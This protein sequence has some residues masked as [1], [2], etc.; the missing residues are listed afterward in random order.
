MKD[1]KNNKVIKGIFIVL[2]FLILFNFVVPNYSNAV[3]GWTGKLIEPLADLTC[4]LGDSMLN[5]MQGVMM[6]GSPTAIVQRTGLVSL[7]I[8]TNSDNFFTKFLAET[9][10]F[11]IRTIKR[12]TPYGLAFDLLATEEQK[13]AFK[14]TFEKQPYPMI[15]YSPAAIFSNKVPALDV[16]FIKP[17]NMKYEYLFLYNED[18]S[19]I[20]DENIYEEYLK[21][22]ELNKREREVA[23]KIRGEVE[24]GKK[25]G[26]TAVAIG[27]VV[28]RWYVA[29]RNIAIVGLMIVLIYI[30]IRILISSTGEETAKYKKM[31]GNWVMALI[32]V[33]F[34]HFIMLVMLTLTELFTNMFSGSVFIEG[35]DVLMEQVRNQESVA[36]LADV[37]SKSWLSTFGYAIMYTTLVIYTM[38]FTIQYLKRAIY[39]AFLTIIAPLVALT[40]PIDKVKDGNAQAF[41]MWLKEYSFNLLLQPIH[42]LLYTI[43]VT[44]SIEF[45]QENMLYAIVAIGFIL[46]AEAF[47]KKMFG[48]QAEGGGFGG[49][50]ASGAIFSSAM[51]ALQNGGSKVT[52]AISNAGSGGGKGAGGN[53]GKVRQQTMNDPN[54]TTSLG[55][56]NSGKPRDTTNNSNVGTSDTTE[57]SSNERIN[58]APGMMIPGS[59]SHKDAQ[60]KLT[61]MK[62]KR[63]LKNMSNNKVNGNFEK[64]K[65]LKKPTPKPKGG[66]PKPNGGSPKPNGGLPKQIG[67][68]DANGKKYM[69]TKANLNKMK[70]MKAIS[71]SGKKIT[72]KPKG[73]N[74]QNSKANRVKNGMKEIGR[75]YFTADNGIKMAKF[76]AKTGLKASLGAVGGMFGIAAGL[77]SNDFSDVFKYG[78]MGAT[79]GAVLGGHLGEQ[80]I[81]IIESAKNSG[82]NISEA[83]SKGA[84][85]KEEYQEKANKNREK[86][87][88]KD[89]EEQRY[90]KEE[91]GENYKEKMNEALEFERYG[92]KD[93][94][95]IR[96]AVKVKDKN[97]DLT[98]Q[99]VA[100]ASKFANS[101]KAEDFVKRESREKLKATIAEQ[102]YNEEDQERFLDIGAQI[103]GVEDIANINK[104]TKDKGNTDKKPKNIR[105]YEN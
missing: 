34:I 62:A 63:K 41:N 97:E 26:N 75:R 44:A 80:G 84:Y 1:L 83:Y 2:I 103:A 71:K 93:Q 79:G 76:A 11:F 87:F 38:M 60:K 23:K 77:A 8:E 57:N 69:S 89:S 10:S 13:E 39:M 58:S 67:K 18:G 37:E 53:E 85:S 86:K 22:A 12:F 59:A 7:L 6:P 21:A 14:K 64:M 49:G 42:L 101:I 78:A 25:P 9:L 73:L 96:Q 43:L 95:Q 70:N 5:I 81:G 19:K 104:T 48:V 29:L 94:E 47:I 52:N 20:T 50:F 45:A 32:L 17:T 65:T 88:M 105:R 28:S 15:Y 99:H 16:N 102:I 68:I 33:F 74:K 56:F 24:A 51:S 66:S 90:Y 61:N 30:G 54:S 46:Q 4:S 98:V 82:K 31:I 3:E 100:T 72:P 55:A 40:Y 35:R 91:Y 36:R 27:D 92:L